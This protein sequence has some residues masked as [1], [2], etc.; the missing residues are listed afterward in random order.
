MMLVLRLLMLILL[1]VVYDFGVDVVD[2]DVVGC[3][4]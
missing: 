2:F 3:C 1:V 4:L